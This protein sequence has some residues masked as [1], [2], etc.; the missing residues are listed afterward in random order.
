MPKTDVAWIV[1][2]RRSPKLLHLTASDELLAID[3]ETI[4]K[5]NGFEIEIDEDESVG[6]RVKLVAMPIS[7]STKKIMFTFEGARFAPGSGLSR[8]V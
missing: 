1:L 2:P 7:K 4:L 3:H 6:Q 8:S 5:Q